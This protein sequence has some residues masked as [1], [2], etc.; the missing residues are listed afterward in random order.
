[1][2]S[3]KADAFSS[4][5][6]TS[7]DTCAQN[8]TLYQIYWP[9]WCTAN[10]LWRRC[11]PGD[12]KHNWCF[13]RPSYLTLNSSWN[14]RRAADKNVLCICMMLSA[15]EC[16]YTTWNHLCQATQAL[17]R[18]CTEEKLY[19][20]RTKKPQVM[21]CGATKC[22]AGPFQ[23]SGPDSIGSTSCAFEDNLTKPLCHSHPAWDAHVWHVL[24]FQEI[25][26]LI[27][28]TCFGSLKFLQ[29]EKNVIE[30]VET[31]TVILLI[32]QAPLL[33]HNFCPA[34]QSVL[35]LTTRDI[36]VYLCN[37]P[38]TWVVH[39]ALDHRLLQLD[40]AVCHHCA[41]IA[42]LPTLW[43]TSEYIDFPQCHKRSELSITKQ[44]TLLISGNPLVL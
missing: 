9:T 30:T 19:L 16:K 40:I 18:S 7:A 33:F 12:Q 24:P 29:S 15:I 22:P 13:D 2:E 41:C 36:L 38:L 10:L 42:W 11:Y 20:W 8:W 44:I 34:T 39:V 6:S 25:K 37:N 1:M 26:T 23:T 31:G 43:R 3:S 27:L 21:L 4:V 5:F 28:K 35:L 14:K 32:P 17:I